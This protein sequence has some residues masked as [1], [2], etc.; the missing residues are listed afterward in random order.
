MS[1]GPIAVVAA[2]AEEM[3][4]LARRL[5]GRRRERRHGV[6]C[7]RGRL[8]GR[9]AV[10]AVTGDGAAAAGRGAAAVLDGYGPAL[11]LG[12]GVAGGLSPGLDAG[13]LLAAD[14]VLDGRGATRAASREWLRR[15]LALDPVIEGLLV[16]VERVLDR[17]EAKRAL[18]RRLGEPLHA[19]ADLESAAWSAAAA[20]RRVPWLVV[21]G[22]SDGAADDLP[23]PFARMTS[24]RGGVSRARV[25]A[26]LAVRPHRL[27]AVLALR[28]RVA[29][30]ADRLAVLSEELVA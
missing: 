18:W 3:R 10:L 26:H 19:A 7:L 6:S 23:L 17:S 8:A 14:R 5:A 21:R 16:S 22:V 20:A 2:L 29:E 13:E 4:P 1:S 27:P 28:R 11:L 15:A 12:L 30:L 24:R 25:L 9:D